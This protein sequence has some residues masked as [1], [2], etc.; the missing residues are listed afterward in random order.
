M[1]SGL[2]DYDSSDD[3]DSVIDLAPALRS[4]HCHEMV[5]YH[6]EC[7]T[8]DEAIDTGSVLRPPSRLERAFE[9]NRLQPLVNPFISQRRGGSGPALATN[10]RNRV[11]RKKPPQGVR[12][13]GGGH[14]ASK[15]PSIEPAQRLREFPDQCLRI[16]AGKLFCGCCKETLTV[17]KNSIKTHVVSAKH[18]RA[19]TAYFVQRDSDLEVK[20]ALETYFTEHNDDSTASLSPEIHLYRYRVTEA[21]MFAG[22]PI[23]K[24]DYLRPVLERA[25]I[26]LT[27]SEHLS[28]Y[29][30]KVEGLEFSAI[31]RELLGESV[32]L[33]FDGTRRQG[34]ALNTVARF[35]NENFEILLRLIQFVTLEHS[36]DNTTLSTTLTTLWTRQY[37]LDFEALTGWGRDSCKV[38]GTATGRLQV[39]FSRSEDLL[40]ICH[41]LNNVGDYV[42][43][44]EKRDFMTSWRILVQN[45]NAAK[46]LWKSFTNSAMVGFS[47]V[48]WWSRQEVENEICLNFGDLPAFLTALDTQNVGDATTRKMR[49]LY[50]A[51]PLLLAM[52]L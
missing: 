49:T 24:T 4:V 37:G 33:M 18:T 23:L 51:D 28:Q 32:F 25:D 11:I 42:G 7:E 27:G 10:E 15:E 41:T 35:C 13:A 12:R 31:H 17:I 44:P 1:N 5:G 45:N 48:R 40:C 26:K 19:K 30:P 16:S 3:S 47:N 46:H 2:V 43:F 29:I 34:E 50:E 38:N 9:K 52:L 8:Q 14:R 6:A 22:I 36:P 21:M 20:D 39:I